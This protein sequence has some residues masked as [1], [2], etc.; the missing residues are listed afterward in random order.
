VLRTRQK[1]TKAIEAAIET[2]RSRLKNLQEKTTI[3][4]TDIYLEDLGV[5]Q[6]FVDEAISQDLQFATK[7]EGSRI[8][9]TASDGWICNARR[10]IYRSRQGRAWYCHR[11]AVANTIAE[12]YT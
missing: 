6:V 5:D 1:R 2:W 4:V 9:N 3:S 11:Y 10:G 8:P 7:W 12:M